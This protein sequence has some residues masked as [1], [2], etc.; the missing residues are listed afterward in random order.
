MKTYRLEWKYKINRREKHSDGFDTESE[1]IEAIKNMVAS[2]EQ[3]MTNIKRNEQVLYSKEILEFLY[4][5]GAI[6]PKQN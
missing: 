4:K 1:L 3:F 6:N 2:T 5:A